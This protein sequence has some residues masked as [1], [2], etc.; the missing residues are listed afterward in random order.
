LTPLKIPSW[1]GESEQNFFVIL[2]SV[3]CVYY[4]NFSEKVKD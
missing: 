3:A 1:S 2:T 4:N